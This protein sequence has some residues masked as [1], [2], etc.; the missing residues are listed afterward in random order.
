MILR[1]V[2]WDPAVI[3]TLSLAPDEVKVLV[4]RLAEFVDCFKDCFNNNAQTNHALAY[5]KGLSSDLP[6]KSLEPIAIT[7]FGVQ[8]VRALQHFFTGSNWD[9][10]L[11]LKKVPGENRAQTLF[12][13]WYGYP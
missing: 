9:P 11:L 6:S 2:E 7:I 3:S 1:D 10:K 8:R 13:R 4:N 5:L 12:T